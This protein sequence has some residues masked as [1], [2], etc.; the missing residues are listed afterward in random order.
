MGYAFLIL[1]G[2]AVLLILTTI[3]LRQQHERQHKSLE[4][5]LQFRLDD[6]KDEIMTELKDRLEEM[7]MSEQEKET[8]AF[9]SA[10]DLN[11]A[12]FE[13]LRKG[14]ILRL[15]SGEWHYPSDDCFIFAFDYKH[16]HIGEKDGFD[17]EV[18]GFKRVDS[19]NDE[20][21][22]VKYLANEKECCTLDK[23]GNIKKAVPSID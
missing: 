12:F 13:K 14:Q 6:L 3:E 17:Y 1:G 23:A 11:L 22:P 19:S 2:V 18:H 5:D 21:K 8:Q 4:T 15:M 20:W 7:S 9:L 10:P 16:D